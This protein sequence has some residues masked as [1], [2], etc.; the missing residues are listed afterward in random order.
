MLEERWRGDLD[1]IVERSLIRVLVVENRTHYFV[2]GAELR[3]LSYDALELFEDELNR[4]LGRR[5]VRVN[6]AYLPVHRGEI[7]ALPPC[8]RCVTRHTPFSASAR[9]PRLRT[10]MAAADKRR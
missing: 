10:P 7:L 6:V 5:A 9:S 8:T 1:G 4:K 2:D 3:G